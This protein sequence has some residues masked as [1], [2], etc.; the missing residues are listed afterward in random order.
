MRGSDAVLSLF[1]IAAGHTQLFLCHDHVVS[2]D[3]STT[4]ESSSWQI[5]SMEGGVLVGVMLCKT[6][7]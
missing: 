5:V 3:T 4:P 2:A 1:L 6:M 7:G